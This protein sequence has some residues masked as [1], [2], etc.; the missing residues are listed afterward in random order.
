M[1]KVLSIMTV[2]IL[3]M[4][5]LGASVFANAQEAPIIG[6]GSTEAGAGDTISLELSITNNPGIAGLAVSVK[7]DTNALTLTG[8]KKGDLFSG[9]TA[10]LNYAW[11][12]SFDVTADGVLATFTFKLADDI[13]PGEYDIQVIVRSCTNEDFDDVVC[14][15]LSGRITVKEE[16]VALTGLALDKTTASGKTGDTITLLPIFTPANATNKNVTWTSSNTA[17]A[18]VKDGVVTTVKAGKATITAKAE[19]GGYEASCVVT[20][21]CAHSKVTKHEAVASTCL[22]QGHGAYEVCDDCG[23]IVSGSDAKLPYANHSYAEK[24]DAKYLKTAATCSSKAVYYKSCSVCGEKSSDTFEAGGFDA[25]NHVGETYLKDKKDATCTSEGYTGDTYCSSCDVILEKGAAIEKTPHNPSSSWS[26]DGNYHWKECQNSGCGNVTDKAAHSGGSATCTKKAV[27]SVCGKEYGD[28]D[29]NKHINTEIRGAKPATEEETGYTGDTYCKDCGKVVKQGEVIPKLD[30][31]HDMQAVAR[32]EATCTSVGNIAYWTCTKCGK[33]YSSADGKVEIKLEDTVIEK[34]AHDY[35]VIQSDETGH[36]HKCK[37]CDAATEKSVH[38]GGSATC[39]EKAVCT[40]CGASYGEFAS[41]TYT[42]NKSEKYLKTKAT[43]VVKAVYYKSCSVCGIQSAE[44]FEG[45]VDENNHANWEVR[46]RIEASAD[47]PGYTGDTYCTDCGKKIKNGSEIPKT[48]T[49]D[50][51]VLQSDE[52]RHWYECSGCDAIEMPVGHAGGTATCTQKKICAVCGTAYGTLGEHLHT[53]IRNK[54]DATCTANGY[55]GDTYCTDCN[56]KVADG[57]VIPAAGHK[58]T[59]VSAKAATHTVNGNIEYYTCSVCGKLFADANASREISLTDTV[60]K[61]EHSYGEYKSDASSHWKECS[62][63][64]VTEKAA[65]SF[66]AW[67]VTK[68]ATATENGTEERSCTV[69]GYSEKAEIPALGEDTSDVSD[70]SDVSDASD[71]S[72]VSNDSSEITSPPT[73]DTSYMLLLIMLTLVSAVATGT[74]A[75]FI[76]KKR[77]N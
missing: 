44:T 69:C 68:E 38:T 53:E 11:D 57:K 10:A 40:V 25:K 18:T 34:I 49:H 1:K 43:C 41:H 36:W 7:Y 54:A 39:A 42:E 35:S 45:D 19:D 71:V 3:L 65:H 33:H 37:N 14:D 59:K 17:V 75:V 8:T 13:A 56:T 60:I 24:V 32:K 66:G 23:E 46:G 30:H 48:H 55:T 63:G 73:G 74:L 21:E 51:S 12:E 5:A 9:Y 72:E 52:Y 62:C 27:C 76:R 2:L 70:V 26:S 28:V 6:F 67:S 31:T 20:V 29:A 16:P 15:V 47:K 50:Y 58:L 61:G 4:T 77:A 64:D 22:V